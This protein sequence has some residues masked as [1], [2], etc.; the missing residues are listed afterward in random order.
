MI[1][2]HIPSGYVFGR[3]LQNSGARWPLILPAAVVGGILPDFDMIWF[4]LIDDRA[5]H[6]HRYWVHIPAFWALVAIAVLPPLA[7]TAKRFLPAALAFFAALFLH[8]C[9]DTLAGDILWHWPWSNDFTHFVTI[10]AV[11]D[12]WVLNFVLHWVFGLEILIWVAAV[13]LWIKR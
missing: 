11:Y 3:L 12:W 1:T 6:H 5:F 13:W 2:A 4:Y 9:L 10:P 7:L 8:L